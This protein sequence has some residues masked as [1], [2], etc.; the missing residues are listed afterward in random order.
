MTE[1]L[2]PGILIR[3][4]NEEFVVLHLLD[5]ET[6]LARSTTDQRVVRLAV[7]DVT[8]AT[9][10]A[11]AGMRTELLTI[12]DEDWVEA[13]RRLEAIRPLL[14]KEA[15]T[16]AD[17]EARALQIN[18]HPTTL[19]RW[20]KDYSATRRLSVLLPPKPSG[21]RGKSRLESAAESIVT[22]VVKSFYLK[23]ERPTVED[24]FRE[25][26][27]LCRLADVPAP[28]PAT[29]RRRIASISEEE[30][31]RRRFGEKRARKQF[32][33]AVGDFPGADSPLAVV[34]IDH[35]EVDV[36]IV[37]EQH[38]RPIG[39]PYL[40]V[41]IDVFS[42][43]IVGYYLSLDPP[44]STSVGM[45][46][47]HALLP[48]DA[49]LAARQ[50]DANWPCWGLMRTVHVDNAKEFRGRVLERACQEYG[51]ALEFR[52]KLEPQFGGHIE[53]LLGTKMKAV[54]RLRGSLFSNPTA[55]GAYRSNDRATFTLDELDAWIARF[56]AGIYHNRFHRGIGTT[57]LARWQ[58]GILGGPAAP[59]IG[60][61]A[62]IEDPERLR[63]DFLPFEERTVQAS[64]VQI[65]CIHYYAD[66]LRPYI[67]ASSPTERRTKRKFLF[68]RDPRDISV[69]QFLDPSTNRYY[70][71]PYRNT[72]RPPMSLWELR[73]ATR[74]SQASGHAVVDE[75][76][77][78]RTYGEM[79]AIEARASATTTKVR[80]AQ[81]RRKHNRRAVDT[82]DSLITAGSAG[83]TAPTRAT[84]AAK[85]LRT[86]ATPTFDP[87]TITAFDDLDQT[88]AVE[89]VRREAR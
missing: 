85:H 71:V 37:D 63:L 58:S 34:Q 7:R 12:P 1:S 61:P 83:E 9:L 60:I 48:K 24:T 77:I 13:H 72:A 20:L 49:W 46:L 76:T 62:R 23:P 2:T 57:P 82:K 28:H 51:I 33:P 68:R 84:P 3:F 16:R 19:Y 41:A 5:L 74:R 4:R 55:R 38:R 30:V 69:V 40:T 50:I 75:D 18:R 8:P 80:R 36:V 29:V 31:M 79:R 43:V 86:V 15:R 56:V 78:F 21:G 65:D 67:N 27:R 45:C 32:S 87:S 14:T 52:P 26:E 47:L 22:S 54:Q 73:E 10:T 17:V 89:S 88:V 44:N 59:G 25:V 39:R 66:I 35:T 42:R 11:A 70:P 6:I 81:S 53:R 64:G